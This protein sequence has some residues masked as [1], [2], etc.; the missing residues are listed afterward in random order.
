MKKK[1]DKQNNILL[2][3]QKAEMMA[4]KQLKK[5]KKNKDHKK[6]KKNI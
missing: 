4:N 2:E 6:D 3:M 5:S 1:G